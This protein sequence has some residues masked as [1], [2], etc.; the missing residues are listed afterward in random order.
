ML[1]LIKKLPKYR[2][3][4]IA[5]CAIVI[6]LFVFIIVTRAGNSAAD[7]PLAEIQ[8]K[9]GPYASAAGLVEGDA[10]NLQDDFLLDIDAY[11]DAY[12]CYSESGLDARLLLVL[13]CRDENGRDAAYE[14]I[15]AYNDT[16]AGIFRDYA[17]E[18]YALL[19]SSV[20]LTRGNYCFYAVSENADKWEEAFVSLIR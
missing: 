19:K 20:M 13:K 7:V 17:P 4:L 9:M 18:Q 15:S 10:N 14:L 12:Y 3:Y 1:D 5:E 6:A 16:Q 11:E 8:T 2:R